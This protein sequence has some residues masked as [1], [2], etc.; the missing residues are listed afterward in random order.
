MG[1]SDYFSRTMTHT[2]GDR[3]S[4]TLEG[5]RLA[6][7]GLEY[8]IEAYDGVSIARDGRPDY[9]HQVLVEDKPTVTNV[10]PDHGPT[11]GGTAVTLSGSNFKSE[12]TVTFGGA[13]AENVTILSS[14][15]ITCTTPAHFPETVDVVVTNPDDQSGT[16]LQGFTYESDVAAVG[17]PDVEGGQN[18]IIQVPIN[19]ANVE[20]LAAADL[21]VA[22]DASVLS[23]QGADTG[24]LTPGWSLAA[25]TNTAGQI[26]LSLASGGGT[27]SSS[28][29]LANLEFEVVGTPAMTS[30]LHIQSVSFND[31]AIP[32]QASNGT[33]LVSLVYD[34]SGNIHFWQNSTSISGTLL[35]LEGEQIHS[36]LSDDSGAY[37]ISNVP[38][39]DYTLTPSKSDQVTGISAYDASQVL[40]HAAGLL[41]LNGHAFTAGDVNKSGQV[42][43]MDAFYILQKAVDLIS[44]P[45]TGAG[46]VWDFDP[47]SRTYTGLNSDQVHQDFTGI[48]LGDVS[49]NWTPTGGLNNQVV[50]QP[51]VGLQTLTATLSL[52]NVTVLPGEHVTVPLNLDLPEGQVYGVDLTLTYDPAVVSVTQVTKGALTTD[53]SA[54]VNTKTPGEIR[55]ALAGT[56]SVKTNGE[57]LNVGFNAIGGTGAVSDL[58]LTQGMLNEKGIP[59][60]L[61]PGS[62]RI[63][64]E[65][66]FYLPLI[67][68]QS[69]Q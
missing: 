65:R 47:E 63:E 36:G 8:Y 1:A 32:V 34:V 5:S 13:V 58:V 45:F 57:L 52:P 24:T 51:T 61:N 62:L 4:A 19:V 40:Q 50:S 60:I 6:S 43:S 31:G 22:F 42:T 30:A 27:A 41:T 68:S 46:V 25:N 21:T 39:G 16:L 7:P 28:G 29:T 49:G 59:T 66:R 48:L 11:S 38:E 2:T 9:P 55:V 33:F 64:G 20:G 3:Y 54:A 37:S 56:A 69:Q 12:A 14:S 17:L 23:A 18:S 10:S 26:T 53:W 35:R 15:Q 44:L 67:L